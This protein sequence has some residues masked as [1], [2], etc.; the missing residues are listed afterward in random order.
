MSGRDAN[1]HM[2]RQKFDMQRHWEGEIHNIQ[3]Q[4]VHAA[5]QGGAPRAQ[6]L[7]A[8]WVEIRGSF[9]VGHGALGA[10]VGGL[11]LVLGPM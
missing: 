2:Q 11:V 10:Y 8:L 9:L 7:L 6:L 4:K 5:P 1:G 3:R